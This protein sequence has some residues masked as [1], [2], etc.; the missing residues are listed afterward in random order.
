M[1]SKGAFKGIKRTMDYSEYGG[2]PLLGVRGV[3]VIG[4]GK[5]ERQRREECHSRGRGPCARAGE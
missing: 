2:A 1:L 3:C 5:I 4:H